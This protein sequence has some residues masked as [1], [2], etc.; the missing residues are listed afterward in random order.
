L[1]VRASVRMRSH[2]SVGSVVEPLFAGRS[3][4]SLSNVVS[5]QPTQSQSVASD[6]AQTGPVQTEPLQSDTAVPPA[7][8]EFGFER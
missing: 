4:E 6:P 3:A 1:R 7:G 2:P 8:G 5:A